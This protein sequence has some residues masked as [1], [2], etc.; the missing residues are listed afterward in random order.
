MSAPGG[1]S[2]SDTVD[3]VTNDSDAKVN[4]EWVKPIIYIF[5]V[6]LITK[7]IIFVIEQML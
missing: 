6:I 5:N 1:T 3:F 4:E 2:I 7:N